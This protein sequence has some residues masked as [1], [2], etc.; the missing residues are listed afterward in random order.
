MIC[1]ILLVCNLHII[2]I[3]LFGKSIDIFASYFPNHQPYF[4][5]LCIIIYFGNIISQCISFGVFD[6]FSGFGSA[7][8][9]SVYIF[10]CWVYL[11][12]FNVNL[13]NLIDFLAF[14]IEP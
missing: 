1:C 13:H 2:V 14:F 5:G 10:L 3:K 12:N 9:K 8:F 4:F 11:K 6:E 7:V